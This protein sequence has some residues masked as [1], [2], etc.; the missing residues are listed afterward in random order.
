[1][2][3]A[4]TVSGH[5]AGYSSCS[6]RFDVNNYNESK[7]DFINRINIKMREEEDTRNGDSGSKYWYLGCENRDVGSI[8]SDFRI[9]NA[10]DL[11]EANYIAVYPVIGWWRERP[12]LGRYNSKVRYSLVI[13]ISTPEVDVD[14]YTPIITQIE[15]SIK[16]PVEI[17]INT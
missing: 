5:I 2:I 6:L 3:S 12:H 10:V 17:K 14:L 7:K 15:N 1:M 9:Q 13:S 16:N 4:L 8:H 11:C